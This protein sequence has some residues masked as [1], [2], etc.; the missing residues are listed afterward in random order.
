M[1]SASGF[2]GHRSSC[3]CTA[4]VVDSAFAVAARVRPAAH[5]LYLCL[6]VAGMRA[7][8]AGYRGGACTRNGANARAELVERRGGSTES[9]FPTF[10]SRDSRMA[11]VR[12]MV[13]PHRAVWLRAFRRFA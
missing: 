4:L 7:H 11:G 3:T 9:A 1:T 2:G 8:V 5:G 13:M 6:T 12:S 10:V